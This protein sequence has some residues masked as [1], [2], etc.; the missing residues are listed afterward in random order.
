MNVISHLLIE[1]DHLFSWSSALVR[2]NDLY[3]VIPRLITGSAGQQWV[4]M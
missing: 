4:I 2:N 1:F 3:G